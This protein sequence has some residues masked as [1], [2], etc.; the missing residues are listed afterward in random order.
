MEC[1]CAGCNRHIDDCT[2][3][4]GIAAIQY[5]CVLSERL[6][7]IESKLDKQAKM[8][9]DYTKLQ[10]KIVTALKGVLERCDVTLK[11]KDGEDGTVL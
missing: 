8:L 4:K 9:G 6:D 5:S 1:V 3:H 2:C 7:R 11:R 10:C